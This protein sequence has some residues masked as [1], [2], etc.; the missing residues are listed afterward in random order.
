MPRFSKEER[1]VLIEVVST[2]AETAQDAKIRARLNSALRKLK[3]SDE[4]HAKRE[5]E[6]RKA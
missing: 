6:G 2:F 1:T 4:H 5:A 3:A